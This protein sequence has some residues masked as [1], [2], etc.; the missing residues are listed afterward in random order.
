MRL[1][2]SGDALH[3]PAKLTY[4]RRST[5]SGVEECFTTA[6]PFDT[7]PHASVASASVPNL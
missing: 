7:G 5:V 6:F 3:L 2:A 1:S 4:E